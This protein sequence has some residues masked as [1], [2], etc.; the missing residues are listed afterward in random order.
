MKKILIVLS[1]AF[2]CISN[3]AFAL[4][5]DEFKTISEKYKMSVRKDT[6]TNL[7]GI[8]V[9]GLRSVK[10]KYYICHSDM[11]ATCEFKTYWNPNGLSNRII[12]AYPLNHGLPEYINVGYSDGSIERYKPLGITTGRP[13]G[14]R[15]LHNI[16][17]ADYK[18]IEGKTPLGI[19]ISL[20]TG[21]FL[22][23]I[24]T[25]EQKDVAKLQEYTN[26]CLELM[27]IDSKK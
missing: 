19:T 11:D 6:Q 20:L 9:D 25:K 5:S 26:Y 22:P 27:A 24:V 10:D 4:T 1:L 12:I 7:A 13:L 23:V 17:Y 8:S 18:P 21:N 2:C 15:Y 16:C 14:A 3:L